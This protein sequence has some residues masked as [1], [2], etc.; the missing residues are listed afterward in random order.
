[1]HLEIRHRTTY[2]Y[3]EPV[4]ENYN[5]LRLQPVSDRTQECVRYG[6]VTEPA[7][8]LQRYHDFH[9]NLV[10]HFYVG[11]SHQLLV[12]EARSEVITYGG[13]D[14]WASVDFPLE[15]IAECRRM[16]RCFDFLQT[17]GYV[18]RDVGVWR[19]AQD[20][21]AGIADAGAA[22]RA[23]AAFIHREFRYDP[24]ATTVETRM[25][26]VLRDRRGVCQDFAHVL[27]GMCRSLG[28]PARY[29]SGY[30]Y[31]GEETGWRGQ[32]ASHAWVEIFLPGFDWLPLDPTNAT[33]PVGEQH[34]KVAIG[35]DY[36]DAAP[37]QGN[38]KGRAVQNLAVELEITRR[39]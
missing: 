23:M 2:R 25:L 19:L 39:A 26:E 3:S 1:M 37:L 21:T 5:E 11:E 6:V 12:V 16:E 36:A 32:L 20:V 35:R 33:R 38:F 22:A 31:V 7:A 27:V 28:I 14:P 34:V 13:T 29:V 4:S 10:D 24:E 8:R 30:L 15:R 9:L 18:T 17:T